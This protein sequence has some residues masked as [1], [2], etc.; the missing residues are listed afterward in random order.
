VHIYICS[1]LVLGAVVRSSG[2]SGTLSAAAVEMIN[3]LFKRPLGKIKMFE[4]QTI[5]V[6]RNRIFYFDKKV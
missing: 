3:V 5:F 4:Y 6:L 2:V 1:A